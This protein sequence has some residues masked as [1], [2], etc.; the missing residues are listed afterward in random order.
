MMRKTSLA[1]TDQRIFFR[2]VNTIGVVRLTQ[3][4]NTKRFLPQDPVLLVSAEVIGARVKNCSNPK[5]STL[6][7]GQNR[8]R[9]KTN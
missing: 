9:E 8:Q 3:I 4:A 2:Y 5:P 6:P 7:N 1:N